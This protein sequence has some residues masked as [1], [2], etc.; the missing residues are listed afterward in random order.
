MIGEGKDK[1]RVFGSVCGCEPCWLDGWEFEM[2]LGSFVDVPVGD[3]CL[4]E[5]RERRV[6]GDVGQAVPISIVS[7][8]HGSAMR[9]LTMG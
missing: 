5:R 4:S 3:G 1:F 8:Y 9:G 6:K 7:I 2:D